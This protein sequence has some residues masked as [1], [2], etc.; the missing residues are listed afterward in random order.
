MN[1]DWLINIDK[2][3]LLELNGSDS[4]F[5]DYLMT[6]ITSTVAWIPVAIALL[7]VIIKNN[8]LRETGLIILGIALTILIADQFTSSFCKP[9]FARFRP[10]QDPI[11]MYLVDVVDG[12]RGGRYGFVSSHAANTFGLALFISLLIKNKWMSMSMFVWA[13]L[14]S[15]SRIYL[16]VHYL[17]D[18]L[19]GMLIGLL[20]GFII[21]LLYLSIIKRF[22]GNKRNISSQYTSSGYAIS[23]LNVFQTVLYTT[24]LI[25]IIRAVTII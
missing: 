10:A 12:Y 2:N 1:I 24:Y 23:D 18:I 9:F 4:L 20:T 19:C 13:T 5:W 3:I 7:Y 8:S 17:G 22:T 11:I 21:Y 16:G 14:C 25:L 6:G 15:Y